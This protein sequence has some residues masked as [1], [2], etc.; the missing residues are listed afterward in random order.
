LEIVCPNSYSDMSGKGYYTT[1]SGTIYHDNFS[2][3]DLN[4]YGTSTTDKGE[5]YIGECKDD[6]HSELG[7][8]ITS[9]EKI[10]KRLFHDGE[11]IGLSPAYRG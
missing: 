6:I 4:G 3:N 1:S 5:I 7:K 8:L 10:Y 2:N 9:E 11:Y